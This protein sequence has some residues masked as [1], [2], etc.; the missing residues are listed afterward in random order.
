MAVNQSNDELQLPKL[1][2][3]KA[4]GT[5][6]GPQF[7]STDA[8]GIWLVSTHIPQAVVGTDLTVQSCIA[9]L[10]EHPSLDWTLVDGDG[11]EIPACE[12]DLD[13]S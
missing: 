5:P 13:V 7:D 12:L 9:L 1:Q 6:F 11:T 3:V 2:F 4:D 10:N 8:A